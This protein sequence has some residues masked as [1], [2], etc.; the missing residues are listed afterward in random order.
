MIAVYAINTYRQTARL[1]IVGGKELVS[2]EGTTQGDPLAMALYAL[3]I[4]P[5]ITCLKSKSSS[6]QCRFADDAS[7]IGSVGELLSSPA[8]RIES[9]WS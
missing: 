2:A 3:R 1:F 7:G 5:L 6:K 4:Q 9:I 8:P